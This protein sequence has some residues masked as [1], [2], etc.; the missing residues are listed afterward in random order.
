MSALFSQII[1]MQPIIL[2]ALLALPVLWFLLRVTPP[3]PRTIIFPATRFL[4]GLVADEHTPS[5]TP[6][7]IFLLRLL[8]VTLIIIALARPVINPSQNLPGQ[9]ALRL[10]IDNSWA[11]AQNWSMQITAAEEAITQAGRERREIYILPT[12]RNTPQAS[13]EQFGPLSF[14]QA[15]S[16]LRGLRPNPWPADYTALTKYLDEHKKRQPL[17][18]LWLSHGLDEGNIKEA[19]RTL[20]N[21]GGLSY[22]SPSPEKL[23]LLLRPSK[24][25]ART[26]DN[27]KHGNIKIN[28]DA[29]RSIAAALPVIVQALAQGEQIIDIQTASLNSAHLPHTISFD[30]PTSLENKITKF[31]LSNKKGAGS[32]FLLDDQF[33]KRK[34]GIAA[35]AQAELSSPL[36][37][38]SYYIKRALEPYADITTGDITTL[39]E[40]DVSV[41]VLPDIAAM[42]TETLNMLEGWVKDGGLLLRFSGPNMAKAQGEQFLL[43]VLIRAGGRSLSGALSWDKPQTIMPFPQ[44]SPFYGLSIP[45]EVTIKQQILADPTQN[46]EHK[47]WA[48]LNDGTPFITADTMDKG[49]I[50]LIHTSANTQWSDFA[51]SG[52]YVSILKRTI[53]LSGL[54]NLSVEHSYTALDPLLIMDGFGSMVSPSASIA[55]IP[56]E[57]LN[58]II[59]S[60]KHPPGI[61]GR[62][63]MQY[64][65]NIGTNLPALK[66]TKNLPLSIAQSHYEK[67]YEIDIMPFI[68]YFALLLFCLDWLIM[69]I[70]SG[71]S[72]L[73]FRSAAFKA[74]IFIIFITPYSVKASDAQ[75]LH[76]SKGLY[77]AYIKTGDARL[78]TLSQRGLEALSATLKR[79]TS[80]E[81]VGVVGLNPEKDPLAFFPF[82]YWPISETQNNY[83]SK[84]MKNIQFYL[85]HGGTILFDT[86][87]QNRS[88]EGII[89]TQNARALRTITASLNI[90][91]VIPIP[92]DHVLGRAFYLL[93]DYPGQFSTGTLWVEQHSTSG[94]DN[95]SSVLIGSNNWI[96][97]WASTSG[98]NA[99]DRYQ[100]DY[101]SKQREMSLRFGVNLVMYVLTGNYKAD[102]VHIPH[103]L[104]RLGK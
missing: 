50:V 93:K 11:S 71:N 84:A 98:D 85:D 42:P 74:L 101:D 69:V 37:E 88:S 76:F 68:L 1:F 77:L 78:D 89:N 57:N 28:I 18:S 63:K 99:Y 32:V 61:Y 7:W 19:I 90:P 39:V 70:I 30:V 95:V 54:T 82:I 51:L 10:I 23:P 21:H 86:R 27:K 79:R 46:L 41:I 80:V 75:D 92:K 96:S 25:L 44:S 36:I 33:K 9:G 4:A 55:P 35:P 34:V 8:M 83:S 6:W 62:G 29:P 64:A 26:K 53:R 94:R 72:A 103:I 66:A 48:Q 87:D 22:I 58:T 12:T 81:P 65:L 24:T 14:G 43:P 2:W 59:P 100:N 31:R 16:I 13:L 91:P 73:L 56:V 40:G 17:Y 97:S 15:R 104:K 47:V 45:D 67:D 3:S 52:L 5:K 102:Q 60:A 49:L 20:Q 38:A